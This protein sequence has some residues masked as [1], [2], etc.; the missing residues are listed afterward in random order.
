MFDVYMMHFLSNDKMQLALIVMH[1]AGH[2]VALLQPVPNQGPIVLG[3]GKVITPPPNIVTNTGTALV[4]VAHVEACSERNIHN[5][6]V[7]QYVIWQENL[8]AFCGQ[9]KASQED[10]RPQPQSEPI[11]EPEPT[12]SKI[13][14]Q[15][16]QKD[17]NVLD[18]GL[19]VIQPGTL[20]MQLHDTDLE[21]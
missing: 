8:L 2:I 10:N 9:N 20:L 3:V 6:H 16:P 21:E 1:F 7:G 11:T 14:P 12:I 18:Y 15:D 4:Y 13:P 19:Q 5:L 17:D